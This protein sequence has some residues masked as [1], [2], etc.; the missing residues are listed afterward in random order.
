MSKGL[1]HDHDVLINDIAQD[2]RQRLLERNM[3]QVEFRRQSTL[4]KATIFRLLSGKAKTISTRTLILAYSSLG[5]R[6]RFV[7]EEKRHHGC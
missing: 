5:L 7:T 6:C 3:S 4:S 1:S 2:L